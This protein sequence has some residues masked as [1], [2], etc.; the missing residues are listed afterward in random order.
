MNPMDELFPYIRAM[1]VSENLKLRISTD[2]YR[3]NEI[4]FALERMTKELL[5]DTVIKESFDYTGFSS[6]LFN[7]LL[8]AKVL[9]KDAPK[10]AGTYYQ[11]DHQRFTDY[12]SEFL[13]SDG[14]YNTSRRIGQRFFADVFSGFLETKAETEAEGDTAMQI[15]AADR[16]VSLGHNEPDY[17]IVAEGLEELG[18]AVR[19]VN[20]ED[21]EE[22]E[23]SRLLSSIY[24]AQKLWEAAELKVIQIKVGVVMVVEDARRVLASTAKATAG[25]LIVDAIKGL[26]KARFNIDLDL[27]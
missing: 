9:I 7:A 1:F 23:R 4:Q 16:V 24:S 13:K 11:N 22:A 17:L 2:Y 10:F 15:P 6:Y 25:A 5:K 20:I 14:I 3:D 19:S 26:L 12:R 8:N 21:I 18:E 27:L